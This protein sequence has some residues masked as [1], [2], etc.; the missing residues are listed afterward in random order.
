MPGKSFQSAYGAVEAPEQ[1]ADRQ[2]AEVSRVRRERSSRWGVLNTLEGSLRGA[3]DTLFIGMDDEFDA[4]VS[5]VVRG[6]DFDED[7]AKR[8]ATKKV[9]SED[10]PYAYLGG[11]IAGGFVPYLGW[12]SRS[13]KGMTIAGGIYGG[14]YGIG[15]DEGDLEDRLDGGL[16]GAL[17]GAG[18]GYLLGGVLMP[19]AKRGVNAG[20]RALAA[21]RR[22]ETPQ[23]NYASF[24]KMPQQTDEVLD[25]NL[26]KKAPKN[27]D[28]LAP[29]P[30]GPVLNPIADELEDGALLTARE[31]LGDPVAAQKSLASRI[32]KMTGAQAQKLLEDLTASE[33]AGTVFD[34]PHFRSLLKVDMTGQPLSTEEMVRAAELFEEATEQLAEKAGIQTKTLKGMEQ[35]VGNELR[36]GLT[37]AEL[38]EMYSQSKDGFVKT[39]VAQ[40][41]MVSAAAKVVRLREEMLPKLLSGEEGAREQVAEELT[42]AAHRLVYARGILSNAGRALG[43]LSHGV[44]SKD[45]DVVDDIEALTVEQVRARV[46]AALNKLGDQGL[47]ELLGRVRTMA[48]AE[49]FEKIILD[50]AE[51]EAFT[52]WNRAINSVGLFLR[53]NA[54]TPATGMFNAISLVT[55]DLFR[56]HLTK[57]VAANQLEKAG[58]MSEAVALRLEEKAARAVY[59]QAHKQGMKALLDRVSWEFW[60]DVERIAAV[61][62]GKGMVAAK[63]RLKRD[64][65]MAR[66]YTPSAMREFDNA[67]RLAVQDIDGF[68]ARQAERVAGGSAFGNLVYHFEKAR[69]VAA[70]TLDATGGASMKLFTASLDDWGREFIRVKETYAQA[71]RFAVREAQEL[72][73][74]MD[75]VGEYAEKRAKEL[76][77][78]PNAEIMRKVEDALL[79]VDADGI[80]GEAAFFRDIEKMVQKEADEVL[81][82]DG[83][84][85]AFGKSS[86]KFLSYDRIG[87]VLPYVKTPIRLFERGLVN[88]G[89]FAKLSKEVQ[90][91]LK[92]GGIEGAMEQARIEIGMQVFNSGMLLGL[93]GAITATNGGFNNSANLD[94]GPPNRL[95]LPGG[96]FVEI[97]RLDPF[98][99]TVGL[100]A[101]IGQAFRDGFSAGTEYDQE[102]ALKA[103]MSTAYLAT[104]DVVL[105]KSYLKGLQE[106]MEVFADTE[107]GAVNKVNKIMQNAA[108]RLIPMGGIS[109]QANETFRTSAI[110]SVGWMDTILRHIPGAGWGMAP[111]VDPL[112]DEVKSRTVGINFGSSERTEGEPISNVKRQLREL[113]IDINTL[114]KSDPDGFD[115]TSE[116]L[117]EVRKI[118]GKEALNGEGFTMS[119][120]LEVLFEDP[121]FKSLPTKDQKRTAVVETMAEFNKPAWELLAE[122]NPKFAS[123]KAYN[124]SLQDYIAEGMIRKEAEKLAE[125]D[126]RMEGLP[127]PE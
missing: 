124:K 68:N 9:V 83:P 69:A 106:I 52:V 63:A 80:S 32:G 110:E 99:L 71:T 101:I 58:K 102:E 40:H 90:K 73:I 11:Q 23:L 79:N 53:S 98:A 120:A 94:A 1:Q 56:N 19:L 57:R 107:E 7:I 45:V 76:S 16:T 22:G 113:G 66:G 111:R 42:Q 84:Q 81:F 12:G 93:A 24:P 127:A 108:G 100:G 47:K 21:M 91:N 75:K 74:P 59:W 92:K 27:T 5:S 18:G 51:A 72:G 122:R 114:R 39:R 82:M 65:M 97:G 88:Y 3:A 49:T 119:E 55:H 96:G 46:D 117:S 86:A 31:L 85:T 35:M 4:W 28:P 89:P 30:T 67:P 8:R 103:A 14:L 38:E 54:L 33:T 36:K 6:A 41:V 121:W 77:S 112:G 10:N 2:S 105:E 50:E 123:K 126:V 43:V 29:A 104:R 60:T 125:E 64:T 48:D 34:N 62:W 20:Q 115:L 78:L 13:V 25:V 87:L 109:R 44:R 26:T 61:G 118:R 116:E 37:M 15:N 17:Y 95:N 70:N